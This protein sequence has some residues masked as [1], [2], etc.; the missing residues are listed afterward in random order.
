MPFYDDKERQITDKDYEKFTNIIKEYDPYHIFI[1][2]D[3]DPNKTH[4]KCFEIIKNSQLN[5]NLINVWLFMG[6]W[7]MIG[8]NNNYI[9]NTVINIPNDLYLNKLLS[10]KMHISQTPPVEGGEDKRDFIQR[11]IDYDKSKVEPNR[12]EED[13]YLLSKEDFIKEFSL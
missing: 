5:T 13:F 8:I 2:V 7:G 6:A 4:N 11:A 1:C 12:Y 9:R 10:I 3:E